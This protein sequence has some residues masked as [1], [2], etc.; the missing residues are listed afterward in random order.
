MSN[1][2]RRLQKLEAYSTDRS[3]YPPHSPAWLEYWLGR[4]NRI[5]SEEEPGTAGCIPLE[6]WDAISSEVEP[7]EPEGAG[8][9]DRAMTSGGESF[10]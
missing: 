4:L 2:L 8:S 7:K 1:I 10:R 9:Q 3:G 6:V 5:L